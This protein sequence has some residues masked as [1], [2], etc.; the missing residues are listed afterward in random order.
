MVLRLIMRLF[1]VSQYY[2]AAL[3]P[4]IQEVCA[5]HNVK[6]HLT[7]SVFEAMGLH[8]SGLVGNHAEK[9]EGAA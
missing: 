9:A 7:G 2:Y 1:K 5:K 4:I 8:M 6:Y 3:A